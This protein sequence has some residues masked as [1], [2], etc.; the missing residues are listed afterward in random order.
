MIEPS[1]RQ[2]EPVVEHAILM[3]DGSMQVR[4][5]DPRFEQIYPLTDW[6]QGNQR[7]GGKV[8]RRRV[9]VVEDWHEVPPVAEPTGAETA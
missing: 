8:Y 6:I 2:P 3:S 9:L 7:F 5:S 4:A 1:G